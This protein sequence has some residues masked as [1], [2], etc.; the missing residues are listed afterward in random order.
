MKK[1]LNKK[2]LSVLLAV[3]L[4]A[5]LSVPAFANTPGYATINIWVEDELYYGDGGYDDPFIATVSTGTTGKDAID[6]YDETLEPEWALVGA[7]IPGTNTP[8]SAYALTSLM[9]AGHDPWGQDGLDA[10]GD[11]TVVTWCTYPGYEGFGLVS[12]QVVNNETVYYYVYSAYDWTFDYNNT[13]YPL[14]VNDGGPYYPYLD[15]IILDDGDV[16][17]L[18]YDLNVIYWYSTDSAIANACNLY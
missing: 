4:L 17:D 9:Y 15:Q 3:M 2:V 16:I 8:T 13:H 10:I 12:S 14:N 5:A 6:Q 11:E 1:I 18:H 7:Y